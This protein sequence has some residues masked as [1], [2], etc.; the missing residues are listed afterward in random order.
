MDKLSYELLFSAPDK[1]GAIISIRV[2]RLVKDALVKIAKDEGLNGV[3][4]LVRHIIAAFLISK[5]NIA[6]PEQKILTPPMYVNI[7]VN[8][9]NG[10]FNA[11]DRELA[12]VKIEDKVGEVYDFVSK[13]KKGLIRVTG[14]NSYVRKIRRELIEALTLALKYGLED[15]YARLKALLNEIQLIL[16]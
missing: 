9:V 11:I 8:K 10:N 2:H 12:R 4:E 13:Y 7:N 6:K 5:L 1:D 15:E 16:D 14:G 3:S